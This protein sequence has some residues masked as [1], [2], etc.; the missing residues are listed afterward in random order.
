M[1]SCADAQVLIERRLDG[2]AS[3]DEEAE[4]AA[5][6]SGCAACATQLARETELD[7]ALRARL[8][9]AAPSP[10]FVARVRA[11]V[12]DEPPAGNRAWVADALNAGGVLGSLGLASLFGGFGEGAAATIL[13]LGMMGAA[14][15]PLLLGGLFAETRPAAAGRIGDASDLRRA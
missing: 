10:A 9:S 1:T 12:A 3:H 14:C 15:Y 13:W 5:H 6:V 8:S 11:R 7:A 2:L 4:L